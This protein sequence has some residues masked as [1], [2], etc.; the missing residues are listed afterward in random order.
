MQLVAGWV[1]LDLEQGN[2]DYEL[3]LWKDAHK[4]DNVNP[5]TVWDHWHGLLISCH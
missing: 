3:T 5:L 2:G 4:M 1:D